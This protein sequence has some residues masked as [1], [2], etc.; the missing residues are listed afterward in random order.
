MTEDIV[1]SVEE[2]NLKKIIFCI[3]KKEV[4]SGSGSGSAPKC[5]NTAFL[6]YHPACLLLPCLNVAQQIPMPV[7]I[8][9]NAGQLLELFV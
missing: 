4:G 2:K 9:K 3:L 1:T 5:H 6:R 8:C 7:V